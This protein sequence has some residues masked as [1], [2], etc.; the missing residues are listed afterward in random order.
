VKRSSSL[1][2][3]VAILGV[4]SLGGCSSAEGALGE[5][6]PP[7]G[8]ALEAMARKPT[9]APASRPFIAKV[10]ARSGTGCPEGSTLVDV[11]DDGQTFTLFFSE[12]EASVQPGTKSA[13]SNCNLVI[14]LEAAN[15]TTFAVTSLFYS[16]YAF[17]EREGMTATQSTDYSFK[18]PVDVTRSGLSSLTGPLDREFLYQDDVA[19]LEGK[20]A[21][22][23]KKGK[24]HVRTEIQITNDPALQGS[25]YINTVAVDGNVEGRPALRFRIAAEPCP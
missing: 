25:G 2:L 10:S 1:L 19:P 23:M 5:A 16:G 6:T 21:K 20:K 17:L 8:A 4:G 9:A 13:Q 14:D 18:G 11:S 7:E 24:L 12:Y 3:V 15:K 22:C